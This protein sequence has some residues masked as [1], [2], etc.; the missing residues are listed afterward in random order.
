[1]RLVIYNR[2]RPGAA[3][4]VPKEV[5]NFSRTLCGRTYPGV[6]GKIVIYSD[7]L[8]LCGVCQIVLECRRRDG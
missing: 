6:L 5:A 1:M 2:L 7:D 4:L 8:H 3:H